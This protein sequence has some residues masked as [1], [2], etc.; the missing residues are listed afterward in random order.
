MELHWPGSVELKGSS[1]LVSDDLERSQDASG[2]SVGMHR[3]PFKHER[4]KALMGSGTV[5]R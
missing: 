2:Y 5:E 1:R 3:G 4:G